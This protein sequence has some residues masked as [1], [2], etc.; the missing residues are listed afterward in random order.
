MLKL[1]RSHYDGS[2]TVYDEKDFD[3]HHTHTKYLEIALVIR[4]NVNRLRIPKSRNRK[5]IVS[6]IRVA[7][8]PEYLQ[9]LK[10][11]LFEIDYN[12]KI[13]DLNKERNKYYATR[14][15]IKKEVTENGPLDRY[16]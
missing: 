1:T 12:K 5:M 13:N 2:Y 10:D 7:T 8:D 3:N 9:K 4:D 6:H 14:N 11:I 16:K 15:K